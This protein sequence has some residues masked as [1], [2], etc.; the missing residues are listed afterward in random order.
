MGNELRH[1]RAAHSSLLTAFMR[2]LF[3]GDIVGKPGRRAVRLLLPRLRER[4]NPD[5]I[6][7]NGENM[8]GGNGITKDTAQEMFR[9]GVSL[10]TT[11]N[12]VWDRPEAL[13]LLK[14]DSRI[15]RPLN[16]PPDTPGVGHTQIDV[17]EEKLTVVSVQGRTF[18]R[19]LDDPFRAIE[20]LL[21]ELGES[22]VLI[23]FH[24]EATAEKLA[25]AY[26]LDG[27]VSA[28]VG[29]HT[30]VP[31]ADARILP[32]GTAYIT[33]V[34]M[35]GPRESVIGMDPSGVIQRF[36]TQMYHRYEIGSGPTILNAVVIE[37]GGARARSIE[38]LQETV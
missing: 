11:G 26:F 22:R 16:Y 5:V 8:A 35:V 2:L 32:G 23:D 20:A 6:I 3:I 34:G 24:A 25:F 21:P 18:M 37:T 36:R 38:L 1:E 17:G 30:H 4:W 28:V 14:A 7:A 33:D 15:V 10:L 19:T 12:H 9:A 31:T 27:K 29:T 13:E